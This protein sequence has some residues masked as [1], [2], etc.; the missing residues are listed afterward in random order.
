MLLDIKGQYMKES[1][2]LAGNVAKNF[3]RRDILLNI[4]GQYTKESNTL[5]GN[6]LKNFLQR[7]VLPDTRE[8]C[9]KFNEIKH[10]TSLAAK[11]AM[12]HRLQNPRWP[13]GGPKMAEGVWKASNFR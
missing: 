7:T 3:P 1:N 2:I 12:P 13:P 11:G 10:N 8:L 5:V 4:K 9:I 6:V